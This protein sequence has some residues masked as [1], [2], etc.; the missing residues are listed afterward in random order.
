MAI[1]QVLQSKKNRGPEPG[2]L[3]EMGLG[4]L[5]CERKFKKRKDEKGEIGGSK[6]GCSLKEICSEGEHKGGMIRLLNF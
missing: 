2:P 1:F 3:L 6:Y 4:A 5:A